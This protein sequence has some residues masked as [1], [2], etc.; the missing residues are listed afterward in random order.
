MFEAALKRFDE[1]APA[2]DQIS[3]RCACEQSEDLSVRNDVL[4]PVTRVD[5]IGAMVTVIH[6]GGLG[7]AAT[8]D[9]SKSGIKA[10]CDRAA[11]WAKAAAA[12]PA[13]DFGAVQMPQESGSWN[14]PVDQAWD[15]VSLEEK[16]A[17][18]KK[19]CSELGGDDRI[20]DRVAQVGYTRS[21]SLLGVKGGG[22]IHQ[23]TH[24]VAPDLRATANAG[25]QTHT[26][27]T[28]MRGISRQGGWEL[29]DG[30][31]LKR[32]A[33]AL[34]G[35]AIA[36][37][38]APNCPTGEMEIVLDPEQMMLQIH[39]SIGHPI[40]LDR[41]LGDERNYAGTSFVT[42]DMFGSYR[43]GSDVLTV[44]F[45]PTVERE[46]AS[47]GF[48]DDGTK[49][50]REILIDKGV[51]IRPLGGSSSQARAKISGVACSRANGW[52][53]PPID[54]MANLNIEP[55]EGTVE[56][57]IANVED[58]VYMRTNTSWSIDDSRNKFQFG[59]EIGE[60]IKDGKRV[61]LVKRPNYR[62]ISATFWRG[63]VEV[64]G[65]ESFAALGTPYCGKGEPNQ[66]IRVGHASPACRFKNV[67]VF[68]GAE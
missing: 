28:G 26:R 60:R 59:C 9:L 16:V 17:F 66:I 18:L 56:D 2:V 49:A 5:D 4:D 1:V 39:E 37:L 20:V 24:L 43:Y 40:E 67:S 30:E 41:I 68:G 6:N 25:S 29:L 35:E 12:S 54:R 52:N 53:R 65:K 15:S 42:L 55:G 32:K 46:F 33:H 36:L 50:S 34:K 61:G 31:G 48:D 10:A 51:L 19:R 14:S 57:L 62:G 13:F 44:T 7:Y 22:R 27:S 23:V 38:D 63:L 21:E 64:A 47:Y 58:G 8:S 11:T 3:I 45:D